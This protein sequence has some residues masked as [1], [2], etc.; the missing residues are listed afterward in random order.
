MHRNGQLETK[1]VGFMFLGPLFL[2][3]WSFIRHMSVS[4]CLYPQNVLGSF[5]LPISADHNF[6]FCHCVLQPNFFN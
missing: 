4:I 1:S 2:Q 6:Y 3:M 5:L